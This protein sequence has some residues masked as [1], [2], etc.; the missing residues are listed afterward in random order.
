MPIAE[1]SKRLASFS[2]PFGTYFF[3]KLPMG[4]RT[5]PN[6]FALLMDKVLKGL[7]FNKALCYLDDI[8]VVSDS[9]D[10][11]LRDLEEVFSRLRQANLKLGPKKCQFARS[12]CIFRGHEISKDGMRPPADRVRAIQQYPP[13]RDQKGLLRFL[14]LMNWFRKFIP[15][16]SVVAQPLNRLKR[17]GVPFQWGEAQQDAMDK[18][19]TALVNS[20]VLAFPRFDLE[21]RLS[22]DTFHLGSGYV[23]HQIWPEEEFP[24]GT[25]ERARTR[26]VRFGS[27]SLT[28][29]QSNYGPTK[30]ELLGMV[31]SIL[32]CATY[33][34]GRPF[35]VLCDHQALKPLFQNKLKG[36]L[37]ERWLA[38]LQQFTFRLEYKPAAQ[39][40]V[41][42]ALS[43]CRPDPQLEPPRSSPGETD[44]FFP[45]VQE[46][47]TEQ[48]LPGGVQLRELIGNTESDS[49]PPVNGIQ[50][51]VDPFSSSVDEYFVPPCSSYKSESVDC[52]YDAD[53]DEGP[54]LDPPRRQHKIQKRKPTATIESD[55]IT[56]LEPATRPDT[57]TST[58]DTAIDSLITGNSSVSSEALQENSAT[59]S[60]EPSSSEVK[61][62]REEQLK[63][64]ALFKDCDFNSSSVARLQ[65]EDSQLQPLIQYLQDGTLPKSQKLSRKLLLEA[66]D[67][68]L[69]QDLLFHS[70]VPKSRRTKDI[71]HYQL[72]LPAILYKQI[73][74]LYHDSPLAAHGGIADTIDRIKERY[75]SHRCTG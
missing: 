18:L 28:K 2:S 74:E 60:S 62:T 11:H 25:S 24:P 67:Y 57:T 31:T 54:M 29:W 52:G 3:H 40:V 13:P 32:D 42:D 26:V 72:V 8:L 55:Q 46:P 56:P 69:V 30:L 7:T 66:T 4:L 71:R 68:L 49:T 51:L 21:F 64:I 19:K 59:P 73:L 50:G 36:A 58:D 38:I 20:P 37:Y 53:T 5:S 22:V 15:N 14:G 6:S 45:Y 63:S 33:L 44:V 17:K 35:L 10:Q 47:P 23:L 43:R 61:D 70:R 9:F 39:M 48:V 34:R 12:H 1:E 65:R 27:K 16:F 41:A 75:F